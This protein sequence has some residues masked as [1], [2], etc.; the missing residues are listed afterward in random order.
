MSENKKDEINQKSHDKGEVKNAEINSETLNTNKNES[1]RKIPNMNEYKRDDAEQKTLNTSENKKNENDQKSPNMGGNK[2][3]ENNRDEEKQETAADTPDG[4]V[5]TKNKGYKIHTLTV[6]GQIEGHNTLPQ[7][8]KATRYELIIPQLV[9]VEENPEIDGLLLI[10]NTVGGDVEAG[11]A[12]SELICSMKKPTVSIVLGGGHSIGVPLAVSTNYS[13]IVPSATMTLHPVRITGLVLGAPQTYTFFNRMQDRIIG[14]IT[15]NSKIDA[16][17]LRELIMSPDEMATDIGTVLD[18]YKAVSE[19][20]INK[21]GGLSDAL[22][23]L[24]SM[25]DKKRSGK[26]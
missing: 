16:E 6:V 25:I 3:G 23:K 24:K 17:R 21:I 18:G 4:S 10:L 7:G 9:E 5:I 26:E 12:I 20:L 8:A 13:F 2:K 15:K 1:N 19:G 11:L 22:S 14:F